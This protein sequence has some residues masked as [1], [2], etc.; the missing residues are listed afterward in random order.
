[1]L[2]LHKLSSAGQAETYYES[3]ND[4]YAGGGEKEFEGEDG[5][6]RSSPDSVFNG[7]AHGND[8][9]DSIVNSSDR[10]ADHILK[11]DSGEHLRSQFIGRGAEILGV[12]GGFDKEQFSR[13]LRGDVGDG[14]NLGRSSSNGELRHAPGWDAT[15]SAP[16]SVSI[17]ALVAGDSRIIDAHHNAVAKAIEYMEKKTTFTRNAEGKWQKTNNLVVGAFTHSASR[18]LDP[19]L[20]THCTI[21]NLTHSKDGKWRT[22]VTN[23][24]Y[25]QKKLIGAIYR[26]YLAHELKHELGYEIESRKGG[27]FDIKGVPKDLIR[28]LSSRRIEIERIAKERGFEEGKGKEQAALMT[29]KSKQ[30]AST[31]SLLDRWELLSKDYALDIKSLIPEPLTASNAKPSLDHTKQSRKELEGALGIV[32]P[33]AE[34]TDNHAIQESADLVEL[35]PGESSKRTRGRPSKASLQSTTRRAGLTRS[36]EMLSAERDVEL[37]IGHLTTYEAVIKE[38]QIIEFV[39]GNIDGRHTYDHIQAAIQKR[40]KNGSLMKSM[41]EGDTYT[42]PKAHRQET[43]AVNMLEQGKGGFKKSIIS[44]TLLD[45]HLK[46]LQKQA[47]NTGSYYLTPEQ[48]HGLKTILTTKDQFVGIQGSAG[49]GKT[50]MWTQLKTITDKNGWTIRGF[51]PTGSAAEKLSEE[52]GFQSGTIDA[53]LYQNKDVLDGNKK[54]VAGKELWVIDEAG[55]GNANHILNMMMLARKS[56]ARVVFQGD[57][58]QLASIEWGK[59]FSILQSRGMKTANIDTIMRQKQEDMRDAVYSVVDKKWD[60]AFEL[61]GDRVVETRDRVSA[62][63]EDWSRLSKEERDSSLVVIPD[64]ESKRKATAAIR[65]SLQ[66][67][68]ELEQNAIKI[69]T[70]HTQQD[71]SDILKGD[72]HFYT[73]GS[74]VQF[75]KDFAR[76]GIKKGER[77]QVV[78]KSKHDQVTLAA[79][80]GSIKVWNPKQGGDRKYA[81]DIYRQE[82]TALA[83]GDKIRWRKTIKAQDLK[84]GDEGIVRKIDLEKKVAVV[85]FT[86]KGQTLTKELDLTKDLTFEH[87]YVKTAFV[88]Q[89]LDSPNVFTIAESFRRNLVNQKSF[90]V[91]ISRTKENLKVYT[92]KRK[93]LIEALKS[94]DAEKTSALESQGGNK[95]KMRGYDK[96]KSLLSL[97]WIKSILSKSSPEKEKPQSERVKRKEQDTKA[98]VREHKDPTREHTKAADRGVER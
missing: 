61:L 16:K 19:Q 89:G 64:L 17:M 15:F 41:L 22:L 72:G 33:G 49:A 63:V 97:D 53:F 23:E 31:Q 13:L 4:Y 2:S 12:A 84:N 36:G 62:L 38:S 43:L 60:R 76:A 74:V 40:V 85:E 11:P 35:S 52:A 58:K 28:F 67:K 1:M 34:V 81:V 46:T 87:D 98:P 95:A 18:N 94:R 50:F 79:S 45:R 73:E 80:D 6:I 59:F 44:K 37:A 20:H 27:Y 57:T 71:L 82:E 70:L 32:P 96:P 47:F 8:G 93:D 86:R 21:M 88:S 9:N 65:E 10:S 42:T 69:K 55:L 91:Q 56:G 51:A 92:D 24:L 75:N 66:Q 29:R 5:E 48:E 78:G 7:N 3:V 39:L 26:S 30:Y 83:L 25:N 77:Y 90:Y 54:L 14:P 68:G